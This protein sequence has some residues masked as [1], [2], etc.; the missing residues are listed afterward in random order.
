MSLLKR[1]QLS[2][3]EISK[4]TQIKRPTCYEYIEEMLLKDYIYRVPV[5][6][7][8]HYAATA[9]TKIVDRIKSKVKKLDESLTDLNEVYNSSQQKPKVT[10]HEGESGIKEIYRDSFSTVGDALSIFPADEYFKQYSFEEFTENEK[11]ITETKF[12]S[13]D[14][15]I[16]GKNFKKVETFLKELGNNNKTVKKLPADFKTSVDVLVYGSKVALISLKNISAVVIDN[17]EIAELFATIHQHLWKI[18]K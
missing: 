13:K 15:V 14:L 16:D 10:F 3:T 1:K 4:E 8:F 18:G 7:K 12:K 2:I 5:G 6:K 17:Q 11:L 9:P